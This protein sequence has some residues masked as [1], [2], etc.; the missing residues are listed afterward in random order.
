MQGNLFGLGLK[1]HLTTEPENYQFPKAHNSG[2]ANNM[3][4]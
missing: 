1:I 2:L 3:S 4:Y